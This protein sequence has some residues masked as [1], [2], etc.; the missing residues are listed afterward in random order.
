M[1]FCFSTCFTVTRT[2]LELLFEADRV[3]GHALNSFLGLSS[4]ANRLA[5]AS[6][7]E[8]NR[9]FG[10][11]TSNASPAADSGSSAFILKKWFYY[12]RIKKYNDTK[13][14]VIE[15]IVSLGERFY[16]IL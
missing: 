2:N 10:S 6:S 8:T 7:C 3:H 12:K 5:S 1:F 11:V 9:C 4:V 14:N 16:I 15:K 13:I